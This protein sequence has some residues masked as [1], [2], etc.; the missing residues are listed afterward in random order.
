MGRRIRAQKIGRGSPPWK[1]PT[2]KRIAPVRYPQLDKPM[3]GLVEELLHE[4]G[5]GAPIAKIKLED[6]RVFYNVAVE[7]LK[8]G[9][10]IYVG[11]GGLTIGSIAP[12]R[13]IPDGSIVCNIECRPGSGGNMAR[14]SGTYATIL[15]HAGGYVTLQLP[16]GKMAVVPEECRAT[17]GVVAGGGRIEKPFLKAGVKMK[18]MRAKGRKWP[19]VRGV[20]MAAV[21]HPHG[22]GRH[23]S[24]GHP[25]TVSRNLPPGAKVGHISAKRTGRK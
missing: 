24:E 15:S 2:H 23:Q 22:G 12:L 16:S 13:D 5:R 9:D 17:I 19:I 21:H 25:T 18:L 1:A 7:S 3:K 8:V 20:A 6:G 14:S 10:V 4:P 11:G